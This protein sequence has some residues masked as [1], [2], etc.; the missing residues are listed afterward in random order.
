M[1]STHSKPVL[2]GF[3]AFIYIINYL[4]YSQFKKH[5]KILI[6]VDKTKLLKDTDICNQVVCGLM[7]VI[8]RSFQTVA[9]EVFNGQTLSASNDFSK[10]VSSLIK[11]S[12]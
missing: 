8:N 7:P 4:L 11:A 2:V 1:I 10:F 12:T 6:I 3:L 5:K 9:N